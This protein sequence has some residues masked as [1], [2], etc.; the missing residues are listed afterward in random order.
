VERAVID[1]MDD[2]YEAW[3]QDLGHAEYRITITMAGYG[4]DAD[5][6]ETLLE[7]FLDKHPETGPVVSQ[8]CKADTLSVTFS[9]K[10]SGQEHA[11][12]LGQVVWA[13]GGA[14]SGLQP[15]H[16]V[17]AEIE[18]VEAAEDRASVGERVPA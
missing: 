17:R 2:I 12:K 16:V 1:G 15:T 10:A 5:A 13:E 7:G 9:L 11:L 18:P 3:H 14:A 8:N 6:A 4:A